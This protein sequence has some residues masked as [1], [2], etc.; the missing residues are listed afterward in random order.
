M[1]TAMKSVLLRFMPALALAVSLAHAAAPDRGSPRS[2][3][4]LL[5][6]LRSPSLDAR[7][8]AFLAIYGPI[9]M[10]T[11]QSESGAFNGGAPVSPEI[12]AALIDLLRREA[13]RQAKLDQQAPTQGGVAGHSEATYGEEESEY[14]AKLTEAVG[15]FHD[16][17][18]ALDVQLNPT[19]LAEGVNQPFVI[20]RYGDAIVPRLLKLYASPDY[21]SSKPAL[22]NIFTYMLRHKL[23]ADD[24]NK[25]ALRALFFPM[26]Y[27]KNNFDRLT[28]A[29]ALACFND[30][31]AVRRLHDMARSDDFRSEP[32]PGSVFYP[33][34]DMAEHSLQG[35]NASWGAPETPY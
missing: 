13:A 18:A 7:E 4:T 27:S 29:E 3:A 9:E 30:A 33:V 15:H 2:T 31:A 19:V 10:R 28:G 5:L 14:W 23:I 21:V 8:N 6:Q 32:R 16:D 1:S 20:A 25:V 11:N 35:C 26:T 24:A 17:P 34:R 22:L 12:R